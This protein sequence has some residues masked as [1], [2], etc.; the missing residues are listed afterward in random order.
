MLSVIVISRG[1]YALLEKC[2]ASIRNNSTNIELIVGYDIDDPKTKE[3]AD[4]FN[5]ITYANSS[6]GNN[7]NRH[8]DILNPICEQSSGNLL[9]G[10]N[11]DVTVETKDFD[12]VIESTMPTG[13]SYGI[14]EEKWP[15]GNAKLEWE[16]ALGYRYACYPVITRTT[17]DVLGFF[18]PPEI[19]GPGADIEFAAI[20]SKFQHL[21]ID[22]PATIFDSVGLPKHS[23]PYY[24]SFL[25]EM[26]NHAIES[27]RISEGILN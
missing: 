18:M 21:I 10:L 13:I 3:V 6:L 14:M 16:A 4:F 19:S 11:D 24:N 12:K 17:F 2:L 5:A 27:I 8:R 26:R 20:F 25:P 15:C 23:T 22:I 7:F 1:R 9:L